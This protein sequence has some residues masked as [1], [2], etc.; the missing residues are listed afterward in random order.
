MNGSSELIER[1]S[2]GVQ[3]L[4]VV[5]RDGLIPCR[6][7]LVRGD[8]G[9]G[10]T[11]LGISY[12]AAGKEGDRSL[13]IGFMEPSDE[14]EDNARAVGIDTTPIEFM[15]LSPDED[16]FMADEAYD[17]F[18]D[19]D[20]E[21]ESI[22]LAITKAL[23]RVRPQ[24][25]FID[26]LTHLRVLS[27]DG[28]QFRKQSMA[29][30]NYLVSCGCTVL[31]TS[32]RSDE[33]P[34]NDLQF[35]ADG[36]MTLGRTATRSVIQVSKFRGSDFD[37]GPHQFR[38]GSRGFQVYPRQLPPLPR[39]YLPRDIR[40]LSSGNKDFDAMLDGGLEAS[41]VTLLTGPTGVGKSTIAACFALESAARG[42]PAAVYIFEEESATYIGR[43]RG[44]G[45]ELDALLDSGK[46]VIEQIEPMRYLADEFTSQVRDHV[47]SMGVE[48]VVLD[49]VEG[50]KVAL[51]AGQH[52]DLPLHAFAKNLARLDITVILVNENQVITE[53]LT[54]SDRNISYLSDNIIYLRYLQADSTLQTTIGVLKKR[55]SNFDHKLRKF[56]IVDRGFEIAR[57][58]EAVDDEL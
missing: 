12:L 48:L 16:F 50:F 45:F 2:T 35:I 25:V 33:F 26:S 58:T 38:I 41:T 8:P 43:L 39:K 34:D 44:L 18:A 24:R 32:E 5:L 13:F 11:I 56:S 4:D 49:S 19:S 28:F 22:A 37:S 36:V 52:V 54:V 3:G 20:D 1:V 10:K 29:L 40:K 14:L 46:L 6:R 57:L 7:Y 21:Q 30:L 42:H 17:V 9:V 47:T 27:V 53:T 51:E 23:E 31:F 15:R 55:L